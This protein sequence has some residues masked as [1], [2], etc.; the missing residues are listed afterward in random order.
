MRVQAKTRVERRGESGNTGD[1]GRS[2]TGPVGSRTQRQ[3]RQPVYPE[4][5]G[6]THGHMVQ[7]AET[8]GPQSDLSPV[9]VL[10]Q[11]VN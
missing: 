10:P 1:P 4:G 7:A 11:H 5:N 3:R 6:L 9:L 2:F 8:I